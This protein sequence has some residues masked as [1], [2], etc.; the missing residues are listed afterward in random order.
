[1]SPL[2]P[3]ILSNVETQLAVIK[4][5]GLILNLNEAIKTDIENNRENGRAHPITVEHLVSDN[6]NLAVNKEGIISI[7]GNSEWGLSIL[8]DR[9]ANIDTSIFNSIL[10]VGTLVDCNTRK[11]IRGTTE[12]YFSSSLSQ[13]NSKS[14]ELVPNRR[15]RYEI[16]STDRS[17]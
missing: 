8:F 16:S 1:M 13:S 7:I 9:L 2:I 4:E 15:F 5:K 12:M 17:S 6:P 14:V 10:N 11:I 3:Y